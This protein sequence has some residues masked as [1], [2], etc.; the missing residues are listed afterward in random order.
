[1][2]L[3]GEEFE[4]LTDPFVMADNEST[5]YGE[6]LVDCQSKIESATNW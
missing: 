6:R 2:K 1:M 3:Y 4:L 5:F